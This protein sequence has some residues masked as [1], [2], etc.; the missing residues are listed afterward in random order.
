MS[1]PPLSVSI[2][3]LVEAVGAPGKTFWQQTAESGMQVPERDLE[4][5]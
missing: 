1:Q 5:Q 3:Q 4:K 2:E